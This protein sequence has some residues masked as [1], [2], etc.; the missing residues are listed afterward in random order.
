MS[1]KENN[2]DSTTEA[3]FETLNIKIP[4]WCTKFETVWTDNLKGMN[5]VREK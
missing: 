3:C 4:V 1:Q 5:K 2:Q